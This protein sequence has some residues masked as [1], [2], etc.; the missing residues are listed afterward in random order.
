MNRV[1]LACVSI[2][3]AALAAWAQPRADATRHARNLAQARVFLPDP[4]ATKLAASGFENA[5]AS[6]IWL[7]AGLVYGAEVEVGG[8]A[9]ADLTPWFEGMVR[10]ANA[11]DPKWRTPYFYGGLL[12]RAAGDLPGSDRILEAGAAAFP[13]D[14]FFPA[15]RAMNAYLHEDDPAAA[16]VWMARAAELPG[17][18]FWYRA[19]AAGM[20]EKSGER[21]GA[22]RFLEEELAHTADPYVR[23]DMERS[24]RRLRHNALVTAW[25]GAC[26]AAAREGQRLQRPDD[27]AALGFALPENPRGDAWVVGRDG[28]VR[29]ATSELE[30]ARRAAMAERALVVR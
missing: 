5:L 8:R 15:N 24:L 27:L 18:P 19:S 16:A 10:T 26:R 22:I 17:A 28:V 29:S 20:K 1:V 14:W 30:R 2:L 12:L 3:G 9:P 7:R 21:D 11:L 25:E 6:L 4:T 13:Q 23:Q